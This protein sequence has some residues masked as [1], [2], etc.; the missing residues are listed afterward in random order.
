[1]FESTKRAVL[2]V[3]VTLGTVAKLSLRAPKG[4]SNLFFVIASV[5]SLPRND[6]SKGILQQFFLWTGIFK[7]ENV[8]S[9]MSNVAC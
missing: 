6:A 4:R 7:I 2:K 9:E 8:H 1:M 3:I 5:A